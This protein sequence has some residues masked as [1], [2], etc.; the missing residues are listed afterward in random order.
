MKWVIALAAGLVV[1]M[2]LAGLLVLRAVLS[3]GHAGPSQQVCQFDRWENQQLWP[4]G[5]GPPLP[6][7][8]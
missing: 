7:G 3:Q 1:A 4:H 5:G 8:C 2:T 6:P